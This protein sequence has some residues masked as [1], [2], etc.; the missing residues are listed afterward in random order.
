M[1]K[2]WVGLGWFKLFGLVWAV[3]TQSQLEVASGL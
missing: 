1:D 2:D 3:G